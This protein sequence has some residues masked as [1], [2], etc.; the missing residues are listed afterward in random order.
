MAP[1]VDLGDRLGQWPGRELAPVDPDDRDDAARGRGQGRMPGVLECSQW[2]RLLAHVDP[3]L[4]GPLHDE[5]TS[6]TGEATRLQR[7]G[8]QHAVRLDEH[9][10]PGALAQFTS[11]VAEDGLVRA[12]LAGVGERADV[13]GVRRRLQHGGRRW[14][15]PRPRDDGDP[16]RSGRTDRRCRDEESSGAPGTLGPQR[17]GTG[18]PQDA[19][20][21]ET[22]PP[23]TGDSLDRTTDLVAV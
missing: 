6:D 14:F 5:G 1:R 15:G 9:V 23:G 11:R 10:G 4:A 22:L 19:H 7:R 2:Q 21:A 20:P 13:L 8:Q 3:R 12:L 17:A 18:A 16:Y